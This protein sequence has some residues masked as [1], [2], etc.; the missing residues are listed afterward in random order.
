ME[1]SINHSIK[2]GTVTRDRL[3]DGWAKSS[4]VGGSGLVL[5]LGDIDNREKPREYA[6]TRPSQAEKNF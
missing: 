4:Q 2:A 3:T 6:N 5:R 1:G